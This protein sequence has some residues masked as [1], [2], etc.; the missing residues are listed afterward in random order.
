MNAHHTAPPPDNA[1]V[2][3]P[4]PLIFLVPFVIGTWLEW[5]AAWP[6]VAAGGRARA[7]AGVLAIA[8]GV[9][10]GFSAVTEFQRRGTTILPARRP[11]RA[12]V[13][14]GPYR[15]TRNPMYLGMTIAYVGAS[16]LINSMWPLLMLPV[17]L[18]AVDRYV[19]AREERYLRAKFG[20]EYVAYTR[21]VRR[22]L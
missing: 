14:A 4:P 18:L 16:L 12:I 19:I 9:A 13:A 11:T 21:R 2:L 10:L 15:F 7:V 20:D 17:V 8:A 6:L 5:R 22:W 1:G 3:L